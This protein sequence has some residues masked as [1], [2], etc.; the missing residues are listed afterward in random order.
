MIHLGLIGSVTIDW[1]LK[2]QWEGLKAA[3]SQVKAKLDAKPT[4]GAKAEALI[5]TAVQEVEQT[6]SSLM[7]GEKLR[8]GPDAAGWKKLDAEIAAAKAQ[9]EKEAQEK[10]KKQ[11][12]G[13]D[14]F[15][16]F[17]S[18]PVEIEIVEAP[19]KEEIE[20]GSGIEMAVDFKKEDCSEGDP[21]RFRGD[22]GSDITVQVIRD[23]SKKNFNM[24]RVKICYEAPPTPVL[25]PQLQL[26]Q[27]PGKVPTSAP[28]TRLPGN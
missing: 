23:G 13:K 17:I 5:E 14:A 6:V 28:P 4:A 11:G 27:D 7:K 26:P 10:E 2:E 18:P 25:P 24:K 22:I 19:P 9:A 8:I 3:V 16:R 12:G 1:H 20:K 15:S 21:L